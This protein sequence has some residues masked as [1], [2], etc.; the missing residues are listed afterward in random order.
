MPT[1]AH[2]V[3]T[4]G[5]AVLRVL[6]TPGLDLAG[7]G[8]LVVYD[9]VDPPILQR[10]DVLLG[11]GLRGEML[12]AC[13]VVGAAG[14]AM[15]AAV[16]IKPGDTDL[17]T[18]IGAA[19]KAGVTLIALPVGMRWETID[20]LLRQ[21]IGATAATA[22]GLSQ[23]GDLFGFANMLAGLVGGAVTIEDTNSQVLAYST[24]VDDELDEARREVILQ[25]RVPEQNLEFLRA[26]GVFRELYKRS[27]VVRVEPDAR[28]GIRRR[29][30]IAV[31]AEDEV[32]ATLWVLEGRQPL[33]AEAERALCD[34]ARVATAHIIRARSDGYVLWERRENLL[35]NLLEG[36]IAA[37]IAGPLLGFDPNLP[38]AVLSVALDP[39]SNAA[40]DH[41]AYRRLGELI[42]ARAIA[43]RWHVACAVFGAQMLALLPELGGNGQETQDGIRRLAEGIATD[44]AQLGMSVR[45]ACGSVVSDLSG[46][47]ASREAAEQVLQVLVADRER[48]PVAD[49]VDVR[50]ALALRQVLE[51]VPPLSTLWRDP[52]QTLA[53]HDVEHHSDYQHTLRV[54][55]DEFGDTARAAERLNIHPNTFRYRMKRITDLS[56]IHLDDPADRLL[57]AI[58][59]RQR[60]L[61]P[62]KK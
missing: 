58:H 57:A 54:W 41:Q 10:S 61:G 12:R 62:A 59:L 15:A 47:A 31:R 21:A 56:G 26:R 50:A 43:F 29:L 5:P 44:A 38:A 30:A 13:E 39:G 28:L 14:S 19:E 22:T 34:A 16:L 40:A 25:R 35:K 8:E 32:L 46:V 36:G 24:L 6:T 20:A 2:L 48:G 17:P 18:L 23:V 1:L 27:D 49:Q 52:V 4:L 42:S 9:P 51:A 60:E 33:R 53:E 11:V 7:V 45:V 37:H 3:E 55:L